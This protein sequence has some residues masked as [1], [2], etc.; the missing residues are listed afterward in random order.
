MGRYSTSMKK[1]SENTK[2]QSCRF[3]LVIQQSISAHASLFSYPGRMGTNPAPHQALELCNCLTEPRLYLQGLLTTEAPLVQWLLQSLIPCSCVNCLRLSLLCR[4]W[5]QHT[6]L[7]TGLSQQGFAVAH[8]TKSVV[9]SEKKALKKSP[10][11]K[12]K[13]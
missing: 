2:I 6:S 1:K 4:S 10:R 13:E 3:S 12:K 7:S 8:P 9:I 11:K 5:S